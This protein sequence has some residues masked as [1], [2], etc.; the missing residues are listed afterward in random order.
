MNDKYNMYVFV[1]FIFINTYLFI[2]RVLQ[3]K[4][5]YNEQVSFL[6]SKIVKPEWCYWKTYEKLLQLNIYVYL[7]AFANI[8]IL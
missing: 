4:S 8:A 5:D 6:P 2:Y 7:P 3:L 1:L